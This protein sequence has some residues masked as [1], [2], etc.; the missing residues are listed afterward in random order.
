MSHARSPAPIKR[1]V[2][3]MTMIRSLEPS[4]VL[5]SLPNELL[6]LIFEELHLDLDFLAGSDTRFL[7]V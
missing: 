2:Y 1:A 6:F 5:S 3:T 7:L 4:S